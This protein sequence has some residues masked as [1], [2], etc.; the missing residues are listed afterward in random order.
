MVPLGGWA[1]GFSG[2]MLHLN[3][4]EQCRRLGKRSN[5]SVAELSPGPR[6]KCHFQ[7]MAGKN[8]SCML[9]RPRADTLWSP[10]PRASWLIA[11]KVEKGA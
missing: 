2:M 5:D 8:P 3:F 4:L 9:D 11:N 10:E 7:D 6:P 1:G